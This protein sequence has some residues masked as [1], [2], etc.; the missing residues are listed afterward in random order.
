MAISFAF[1]LLEMPYNDATAKFLSRSLPRSVGVRDN[2]DIPFC[3]YAKLYK[4]TLRKLNC[5]HMQD[6]VIMPLS[7]KR[8][9]S[10]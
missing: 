3:A 7:G 6:P 9:E 8:P 2:G 5:N 10:A 1:L 4:Q